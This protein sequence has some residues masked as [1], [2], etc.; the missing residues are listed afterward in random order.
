MSGAHSHDAPK[1]S[2]NPALLPAFGTQ[3]PS[4]FCFLVQA[5]HEPEVENCLYIALCTDCDS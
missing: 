2:L 5:F 4:G 1:R 3:S